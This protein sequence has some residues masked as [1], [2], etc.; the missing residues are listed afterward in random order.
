MVTAANVPMVVRYCLF[1]EAANHSTKLDL[2]TDMKFGREKKIRTEH[3]GMSIP[4]WINNLQTWREADTTKISKNGKIGDRGV[5][6][7]FVGFV[8]KHGTDMYRMLNP[9]T[10]RTTNNRAVI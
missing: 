10:R 6:M 9:H 5:T 1:E 4:A 3:Y 2:L 8:N 7:T